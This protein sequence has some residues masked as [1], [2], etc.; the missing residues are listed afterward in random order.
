MFMFQ[1]VF[2]I[3]RKVVNTMFN[4]YNVLATR[5][6]LCGNGVEFSSFRTH[7]IP[8]IRVDRQGGRIKIGKDFS[9]NNGYKGNPIGQS[10]RCVLLAGPNSSLV[11]GNNTGISQCALIAYADLYVGNSVKIGGGSCVYT[12]DFHSLDKNI[13]GGVNDLKERMCAPVNI[14]D[15]VF[16][17]AR[18]VILKGVSIGEN[19]IIGA[20][21]VVTKSVP[22]NQIWAGNPAKFIRKL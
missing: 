13:R 11:I 9:M 21:S 2:R 19:S 12:T 17:G 1:L 18:C 15:N 10:E 3:I 14:D 8:L 5:I 4:W 16:I 7:G 20:G 22:A 6:L